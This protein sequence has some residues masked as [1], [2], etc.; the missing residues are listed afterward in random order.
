MRTERK[1]RLFGQ[2]GYLNVDFDN[3]KLF[4]IGRGGGGIPMPEMEDATMEH[5]TWPVQDALAAEHDAFVASVLDGAPVRV[6]A[7]AGR[8]ALAAALLIGERMR[9]AREKAFRSGLIVEPSP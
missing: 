7:A 1:M 5:I 9:G 6:D 8:R 2:N 4:R 3:R